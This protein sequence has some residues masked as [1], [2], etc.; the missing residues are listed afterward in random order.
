MTTANRFVV[1][2]SPAAT[3]TATEV[4]CNSYTNGNINIAKPGNH[5]FNYELKNSEGTTVNSAGGIDETVSVGGL[6]AGTYTLYINS[7]T[8]LSDTNSIMVLQPAPVVPDFSM[9]GDNV[10]LSNA[11]I[12]FTNFSTGATIYSWN[13]GDGSPVSSV[14]SPAH[15]YTSAGN[16]TI[17]LTAQN[18]NGCDQVITKD[19]VVNPD[20][21]TGISTAS[22]NNELTVFENAGQLELHFTSASI[23]QLDVTIY[24]SIGQMV[25]AISNRNVSELS[26]NV[27]LNT[28]GTYFVCSIINGRAHSEKINYIK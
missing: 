9:S 17:T 3:I 18:S 26:E 19:L 22:M 15:Q 6:S 27:S 1:H 10:Y 4:T 20:L 28:S 16:Y 12:N 14:V 7:A 2:F 21:T 24:N 23:S 25:H 8:T 13:F 5:N 11:S